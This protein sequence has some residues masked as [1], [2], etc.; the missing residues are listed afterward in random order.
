[1]GTKVVTTL[2]L[3]VRGEGPKGRA[4]GL[5]ISTAVLLA[6]FWGAACNTPPEDTRG[7]SRS[8]EP[9]TQQQVEA[10]SPV[11]L[12][13]RKIEERTVA[14]PARTAVDHEAASKLAAPVRDALAASVVPVLAPKDEALLTSVRPVVKP[15]FT[16]LSIRGAGKDQGLHITVGATRV[17]HRYPGM[18]RI[19]PTHTVRNGKPAWVLPNEGI[20]SVSWEEMGVS[21]SVDVECERPKDDSRCQSPDRVVEIVESLVFLGGSFGG[22][23]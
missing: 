14:W 13:E 22:A 21:Y 9:Q 6:S 15:G 19:E 2:A 4:D 11:V 8:P 7:P 20:W 18:E 3:A 10:K 1:M 17:V 5:R 23:K 16:S 12:G